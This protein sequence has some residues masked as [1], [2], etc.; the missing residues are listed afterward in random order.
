MGG[1][2]LYSGF[3][4]TRNTHFSV[5]VCG[6]GEGIPV[7]ENHRRFFFRGERGKWVYDCF[8]LSF[9]LSFFLRVTSKNGSHNSPLL[10]TRSPRSTDGL[11]P[12]RVWVSYE[13]MAR[14]KSI[15]NH[16]NA[17]VT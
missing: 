10:N 13:S 8:S 6:G 9:S 4:Y 5:C 14:G 16:P 11:V 12:V 7:A 3:S 2:Q 1:N 15:R 17:S